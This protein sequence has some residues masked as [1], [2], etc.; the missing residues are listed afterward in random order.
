M[1]VTNMLRVLINTWLVS[2]KKDHNTVV[3]CLFISEEA[4]EIAEEREIV[5]QAKEE[6]KSI[7][8][9][10]FSIKRSYKERRDSSL[11]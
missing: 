2:S 10:S 7:E 5:K 6:I 8:G 11:K 4:L 3:R 1:V 9:Q